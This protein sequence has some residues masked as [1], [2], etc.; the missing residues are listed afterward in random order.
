M[1]EQ[2]VRRKAMAK[3]AQAMQHQI[4][5]KRA[6]QAELQ[7]AIERLHRQES[8]PTVQEPPLQHYQPQ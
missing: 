8:E 7:Q 2:L 3:R 5:Q 6:I 4:D 1:Q